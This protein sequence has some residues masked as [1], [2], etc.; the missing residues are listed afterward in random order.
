MLKGYKYR[1]YPTEEQKQFIKQN[2]GA[3]RWVYNYALG[4]IRKH[5]EET[6]EHLS[7]QY[8]VARDFPIL[9]KAE[10][11]AWLKNVD[12]KSLI[13]TMTYLDKA[14]KTFFKACK[15]RA[16]GN[17]NDTNEPQFKKWQHYGSYT[18]YDNIFI[19][20][21]QNMISLPK[22]HNI[23]A[24]LHR[25]FNGKIKNAT[26]SFNRANQYFISFSVEDETEALPKKEINFETTIGIDLGI[27]NSIITSDGVK[28]DALRI[29]GKEN[30]RIKMLQK[31]LSRKEKHSKN[32][33]KARLKLAKYRNRLENQKN[34]FIDKVT[35]DIIYN[36]NISVVCI[37]NLNVKGMTKNHTLAKSIQESSFGEIKR[38][39]L[40][41][42]EW[43]GV[44]VI[45]TDRFY[46]S[47]KTCH[48]CGYINK[49]LTLND[50][51]WTCPVCG[52]HHDR[53]LNAAMNILLEGERI[54]GNRVPN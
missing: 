51:E 43:N 28:Y 25:K 30:R 38:K 34:S 39:L 20:W 15:E 16:K 53:D 42:G 49:E 27:K 31:R 24:V 41:K 52:E 48:K 8:Q 5:Y 26:V 3:N 22:L 37:E 36:E 11:T 7:A 45:E 4:K 2:V 21:N 14:Y 9:K 12:S 47:S 19:M 1:I 35:S 50:R 13:Y 46:P 54:M 44:T 40:Y 17:H 33:E 29:G 6:R 32:A 23:R 10:E 18:T